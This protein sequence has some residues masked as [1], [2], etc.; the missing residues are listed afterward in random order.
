MRVKGYKLW[1]AP[2]LGYVVR[3]HITS[4][5]RVG[6]QVDTIGILE[7]ELMEYSLLLTKNADRH[8]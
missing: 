6:D 7:R 3:E 8:R 4:L 1:Y 5:Q 2:E